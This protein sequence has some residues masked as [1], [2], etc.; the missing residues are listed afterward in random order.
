MS[1][2]LRSSKSTRATKRTKRRVMRKTSVRKAKKVVKKKGSRKKSKKVMKGGYG[3]GK[4]H[5]GGGEKLR[6]FFE[7]FASEGFVSKGKTS[8]KSDR[9]NVTHNPDNAQYHF[10]SPN[11]TRKSLIQQR[12]SSE[13]PG[14]LEYFYKDP[15]SKD[16]DSNLYFHSE[17]IQDLFFNYVNVHKEKENISI[18]NTIVKLEKKNEYVNLI[19][20]LKTLVPT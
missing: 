7:Q 4:N 8:T 17:R 13:K 11:H 1:R 6:K 3:R 15:D 2:K 19:D 16:P 10:V 20:R 18:K 14:S 9:Y 5:K 12:V